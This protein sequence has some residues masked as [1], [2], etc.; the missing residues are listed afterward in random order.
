MGEA[1]VESAKPLR[2]QVAYV[3]GRWRVT[4]LRSGETDVWRG[5]L[6]GPLVSDLSTAIWVAVV[7]D[8]SNHHTMIRRDSITDITPPR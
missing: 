4:Y 5:L 2:R 8:G 7:P 3:C 1:V 6:V